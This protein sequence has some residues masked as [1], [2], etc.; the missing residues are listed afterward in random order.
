MVCPQTRA[1]IQLAPMA[2]MVLL[3]ASL[4]DRAAVMLLRK[5]STTFLHANL[6][7]HLRGPE[8]FVATPDYHALHHSDAPQHRGRNFAGMLPV[9]DRLFGTHAPVRG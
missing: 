4:A 2:G 5:T 7:W 6:A 8:R 1:K 9:L 3:G